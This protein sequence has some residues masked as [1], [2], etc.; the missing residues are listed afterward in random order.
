MTFLCQVPLNKTFVKVPYKCQWLIDC[1]A[2]LQILENKQNGSQKAGL[3]SQNTAK[4][5]KSPNA[6]MGYP[7]EISL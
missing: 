3:S 2:G 1:T 5:S 7:L 6:D 4:Y